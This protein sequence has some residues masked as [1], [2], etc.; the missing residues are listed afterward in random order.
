MGFRGIL[1]YFFGSR[2][3]RPTVADRLDSVERA[4]AEIVVSLQHLRASSNAQTVHLET[5]AV[6]GDQLR[7]SLGALAN[8]MNAAEN[9]L[10]VMSQQ[11]FAPLERALGLLSNGISGVGELANQINGTENR[12]MVLTQQHFASLNAALDALGSN[13]GDI[14]TLREQL[15]SRISV[16]ANQLGELANQIN[17]AENR[18][19]ELGQHEM[20]LLDNRLGLH[21]NQINMLENRLLEIGHSQTSLLDNRLGS[22]ANLI[23]AAETHLSAGFAETTGALFDRIA[24]LEKRIERLHIDQL[25]SARAAAALARGVVR[26]SDAAGTLARS[27]LAPSLEAQI[28]AFRKA[29]PHN[30]DGWLRAF[31]AAKAAGHESL[32]GNLSHEGSVGANHFRLFVDACGRGRILDVGCGPLPLPVYLS[33]WPLDQI[34]GVDPLPPQGAHPFAFV[35]TFAEHLPWPDGSFETVVIAT[36]LDHTFLLDVALAEIRRVL[37]R[38]G[39]LLIWTGLVDTSEPYDPYG[40]EISAPDRF[41]LFHPGRNWFFQL[42]ARDYRLIDRVSAAGGA[43]FLAFE[44]AVSVD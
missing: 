22:Q 21:A 24:A 39:R 38:D 40:P 14:S 17:G 30:V 9:R 34:A 15:A 18:L 7:N 37:T 16:L 42:F 3:R 10:M 6:I 8:Q 41:H 31:E 36:S 5:A 25:L 27:S 33:D 32:E 29:A 26:R 35:Q 44:R 28:E 20:S 13:L 19:L 23:N 2:S 11:Q 1:G 43:E 4:I 12:I